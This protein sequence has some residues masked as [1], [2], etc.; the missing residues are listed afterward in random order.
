MRTRSLTLLSTVRFICFTPISLLQNM[1]PLLTPHL[2]SPLIQDMDRADSPFNAGVPTGQKEEVNYY[3][4]LSLILPMQ[5][6][7]FYFPY[8]LWTALNK[9]SGIDLEG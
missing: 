3:Q 5:A 4:W 6:A 1:L 9:K 2:H 8:L 7:F